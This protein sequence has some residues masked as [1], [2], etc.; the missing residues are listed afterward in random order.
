MATRPSGVINK[1]KDYGGSGLAWLGGDDDSWP[2]R[3]VCRWKSEQRQDQ[4]R[5]KN[6]NGDECLKIEL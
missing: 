3:C 2:R 6:G 1:G 5:S 4:P